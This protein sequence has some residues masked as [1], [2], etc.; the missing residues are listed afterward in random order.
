MEFPPRQESRRRA[1][2]AAADARAAESGSRGLKDPEGFRQKQAKREQME[3]AERKLDSQ[4]G[5]TL[6]VFIVFFFKKKT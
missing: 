5:A 3:E 6:K 4:G 2:A 1:A